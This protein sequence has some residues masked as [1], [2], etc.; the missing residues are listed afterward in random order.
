MELNKY[1]SFFSFEVDSKIGAFYSG[2][3]LRWS[4]DGSTLFCC[5]AGTIN[6]IDIDTGRPKLVLGDEN[7]G[8]D[9]IH[10][11]TV[12]GNNVIS[13]HRSGLFKIWDIIGKFN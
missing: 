12:N 2:G 7:E 9:I 13:S 11:F 10:C 1:Y 8:A 4:E 6:L 3:K 5:N